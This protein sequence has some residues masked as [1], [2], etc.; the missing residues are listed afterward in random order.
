[1]QAWKRLAADLDVDKLDAMTST[2]P[3]SQVA[4]TAPLFLEGKVRGRI[5]VDVNR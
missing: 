2:I 1:L 3:L 5:V 4:Q